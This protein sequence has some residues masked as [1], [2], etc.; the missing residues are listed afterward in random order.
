MLALRMLPPIIVTI[1]LF[2]AVNALGLND[3]HLLLVLL[4]AAFYVSIATWIMRA[5]IAALPRELEEAAQV[6]GAGLAPDGSASARINGQPISSKSSWLRVPATTY[7]I[8]RPPAAK[9]RSSLVTVCGRRIFFS[10]LLGRERI[11]SGS[12]IR[13]I[14]GHR[15]F[16]NLSPCRSGIC[17]L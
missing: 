1:P 15:D 2:P 8:G 11:G 17:A 12:R 3:T 5:F 7:S 10:G 14:T 13:S 9:L 16:H 4:Y 6:D